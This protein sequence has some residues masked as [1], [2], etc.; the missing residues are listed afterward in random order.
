[1]VTGT[2]KSGG[3]WTDENLWPADQHNPKGY[4]ESIEALTINEK[5]LASAL[6]SLAEAGVYLYTGRLLRI[7]PLDIRLQVEDTLHIEMQASLSHEPYC[8]K[9][10]RFSY[11]LDI[12]RPFLHNIKYICVF[13]EPIATA[14]SL[15][16]YCRNI[17]HY[18]P[19]EMTEEMALDL[20]QCYY[21]H[22]LQNHST[23]GEWLFVHYNQMFE[24]QT[25]RH[26]EAFAEVTLQETFPDLELRR[27]VPDTS[28]STAIQE[29]Y[30]ELCDRA[31]YTI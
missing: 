24:P 19:L 20:W 15:V 18:H 12:W 4:F 3:Y 1:M 23:E 22:I 7:L 17:E 30:K 6:P 28:Y 26:L 16:R 5:I 29:M 13:R 10:P 11:T 21:T 31:M 8:L 14:H 2:L 25:F 27:A 9:D